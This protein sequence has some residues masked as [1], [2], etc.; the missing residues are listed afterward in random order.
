MNKSTNIAVIESRWWDDSNTS[1]RGTFDLI[2]DILYDSP[3]YYYYEMANSEV[4]MK[5]ALYR[6][7]TRRSC[8]YLC[9]ATHGYEDGLQMH[10]G[11]VLSRAEIRNILLKVTDA[12]NT[13]LH[14]LHLASC[15]FGT[16]RLAEFI[17][18]ESVSLEWISG[19]GE[20][21]N[22]L[23]STAMDMMFFS[24]LVSDDRNETPK[25]RIWRTAINLH[26]KA[27]GL[28]DQL[29]FGIFVRSGKNGYYYN[30]FENLEEE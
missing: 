10:N 20:E 9:L 4:A 26:K 15:S 7:A 24:E 25:E 3:H 29:G 13:K 18:K 30:I 14:G 19:Y 2:S 5:E 1:V 27:G 11:D 17:F 8:K 16:E 28:I 12:P 21:V 22:W 23:D 6:V